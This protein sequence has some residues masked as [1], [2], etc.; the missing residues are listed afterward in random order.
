M[1]QGSGFATAFAQSEKWR[2]D[3]PAYS[4]KSKHVYIVI[5]FMKYFT[6]LNYSLALCFYL[7]PYV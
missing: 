4:E 1:W 6:K 3:A 5:T 2:K 7:A